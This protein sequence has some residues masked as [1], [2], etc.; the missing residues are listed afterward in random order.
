MVKYGIW[1]R[2]SVFPPFRQK[3]APTH[4]THLYPQNK[5]DLAEG[6]LQALTLIQKLSACSECALSTS[7]PKKA[8]CNQSCTYHF[9]CPSTYLSTETWHL[10]NATDA[11]PE[12]RMPFA[13]LH[14]PNILIQQSLT[15]TQKQ[16][17]PECYQIWSNFQSIKA[18]IL[19]K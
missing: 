12:T 10:P 14:K 18:T 2:I 8:E 9:D 16:N 7:L 6:Y 1:T 11:T 15:L 19:T 5:T 13:L 4:I 3:W 17:D